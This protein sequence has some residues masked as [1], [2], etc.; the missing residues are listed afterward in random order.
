MFFF[1]DTQ[2]ATDKVINGVKTSLLFLRK[3]LFL[4]GQLDRIDQFPDAIMERT[5]K[6][7]RIKITC[8]EV[9]FEGMDRIFHKFVPFF[10]VFYIIAV[11]PQNKRSV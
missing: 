7:V 8:V 5:A 6:N 4:W 2:V 1:V 3:P 10:G 11:N 9:I